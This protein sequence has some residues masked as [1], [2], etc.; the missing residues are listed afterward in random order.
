MMSCKLP[1]TIDL[2]K[3]RR[4]QEKPLGHQEEADKPLGGERELSVA[5]QVQRVIVTRG[6][7]YAP[8]AVEPP[9]PPPLPWGA[10]SE[11]ELAATWWAQR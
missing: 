1:P 2:G 5:F 11:D 10:G 3:A 6:H 4:A 7:P 9:A 8:G